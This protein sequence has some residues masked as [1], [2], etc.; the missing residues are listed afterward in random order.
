METLEHVEYYCGALA[1][2]RRLSLGAHL[3]EVHC[4]KA[5]NERQMLE[6]SL[7]INSHEK[8]IQRDYSGNEV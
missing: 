5:E 4:F 6:E 7:Q 1:N 8:G 2:K 3:I